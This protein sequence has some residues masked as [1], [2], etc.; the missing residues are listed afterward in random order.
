[1]DAVIPSSFKK[2]FSAW[3]RHDSFYHLI[4]WASLLIVM[5]VTN[6]PKMGFYQAF[7]TD[8]TRMHF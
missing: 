6:V 1:M 5:M 4:F 3:R 8:I 2:Q 7:I